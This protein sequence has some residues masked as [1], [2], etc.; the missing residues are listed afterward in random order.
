M[1]AGRGR[2]GDGMKRWGSSRVI[3]C[4]TDAGS[5][6]APGSVALLLNGGGADDR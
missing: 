5:P 4:A 2:A 6:D 1:P 3:D